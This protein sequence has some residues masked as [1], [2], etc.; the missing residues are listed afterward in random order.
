MRAELDRLIHEKRSQLKDAF[1]THEKAREALADTRTHLLGL[2]QGDGPAQ[3]APDFVPDAQA[4]IQKLE[5][6]ERD[7]AA[8]F[9]AIS[10]ELAQLHRE[11]YGEWQITW[12]G[13]RAC[14]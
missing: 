3:I 10:E 1:A 9:N 7:A 11:K 14:P 8:R 13:P 6:Q 2:V 12:R 5:S 4:E